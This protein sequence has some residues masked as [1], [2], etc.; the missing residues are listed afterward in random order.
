MRFFDTGSGYINLRVPPIVF[1]NVEAHCNASNPKVPMHSAN[2][3]P[4]A[5]SLLAALPRKEC[6]QLIDKD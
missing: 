3:V 4:V 2:Q 5:N 1:A 6:Q